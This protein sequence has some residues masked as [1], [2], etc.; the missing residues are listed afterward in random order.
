MNFQAAER[1]LH[2]AHNHLKIKMLQEYL[3]L[4]K[5][6]DNIAKNEANEIIGTVLDKLK[7]EVNAIIVDV[8]TRYPGYGGID[9]LQP[10]LRKSDPGVPAPHP[11]A[12]TADQTGLLVWVAEKREPVWLDDIPERATSGINRLS[13]KSI[14]GRYFNLYDGTRAFAAVPIQYQTQFAILTAEVSMPRSLK[15]IML[16]L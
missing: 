4:A 16:T 3:R 1:Q 12:L 2:P 14:E 9:I 10:Y 5:T 11:I 13:G 8:W 6:V 7:A 15:A